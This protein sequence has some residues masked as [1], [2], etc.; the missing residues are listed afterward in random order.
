MVVCEE[1]VEM[2]QLPPQSFRAQSFHTR[3]AR[4]DGEKTREGLQSFFS[5]KGGSENALALEHIEHD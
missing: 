4:P 3:K 2:T 5:K 1:D